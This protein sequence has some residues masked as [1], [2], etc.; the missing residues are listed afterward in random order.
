MIALSPGEHARVAPLF[1]AYWGLRPG[2]YSVIE[3]RQ[4]GRILVDDAERPRESQKPP[5]PRP[6]GRG[7]GGMRR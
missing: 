4:G 3:G 5:S 1:D 2:I 6:Y 7:R